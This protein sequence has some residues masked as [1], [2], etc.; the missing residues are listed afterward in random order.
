MDFLQIFLITFNVIVLISFISY[1]YLRR[2]KEFEKQIR[3]AIVWRQ[4]LEKTLIF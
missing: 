1:E 4:K 3:E 2:Q